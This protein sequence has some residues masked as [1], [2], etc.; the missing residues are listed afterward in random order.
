V[1]ALSDGDPRI[2]QHG[3][4]GADRNHEVNH[5]RLVGL[6]KSLSDALKKGE[7]V[8]P[9]DL[10]PSRLTAHAKAHEKLLVD[11]SV[12]RVSEQVG[13]KGLSHVRTESKEMLRRIKNFVK[14]F[15]GPGDLDDFGFRLP[16]PTARSRANTDPDPTPVTPSL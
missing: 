14:S 2:A 4:L 16:Q 9:D 10:K 12:V 6:A 13:S 15:Y 1:L 11:R 7:V 8:L 5:A 3:A